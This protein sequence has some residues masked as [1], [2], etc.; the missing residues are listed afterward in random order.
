MTVE[1]IHKLGAEVQRW[2]RDYLSGRCSRA[3]MA[4]WAVQQL[5]TTPNQ[6]LTQTEY[7]ELLD[8]ALCRF[9]DDDWIS[10]E[11]YRDEMQDL[12]VRLQNADKGEVA[13]P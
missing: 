1:A 12:L 13:L 8:Y 11:E 9:T 7:G 2:I 10:D 6:Q 3:E 5:K 4:K